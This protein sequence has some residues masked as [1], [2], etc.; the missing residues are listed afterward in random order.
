MHGARVNTAAILFTEKSRKSKV[1]E[2]IQKTLKRC[3]FGEDTADK[4]L[5]NINK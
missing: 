1:V 5:E 2:V 3:V 4:M